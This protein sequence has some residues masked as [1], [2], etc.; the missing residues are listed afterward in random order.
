MLRK[1]G[2]R[3]EVGWKKRGSRWREVRR[4]REEEVER[5]KGGGRWRV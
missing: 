1:V 4:E 2:R 5:G 3:E